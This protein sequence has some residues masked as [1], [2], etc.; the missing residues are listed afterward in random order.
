MLSRKKKEK[1]NGITLGCMLD[2]VFLLLSIFC[3]A[4]GKTTVW[5]EARQSY[6]VFLSGHWWK[7]KSCQ[8][9]VVIWIRTPSSS[10]AMPVAE[11]ICPSPLE[12][13]H[14]ALPPPSPHITIASHLLWILSC[15][16]TTAHSHSI[17]FPFLQGPHKVNH[18][19]FARDGLIIALACLSP[20]C[21]LHRDNRALLLIRMQLVILVFH[22]S[23]LWVTVIPGRSE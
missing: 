12:R 22:T 20:S 8:S 18:N 14:E 11:V 2:F 7:W 6:F 21:A 3:F 10:T 4:F 13:F 9:A 5:H 19:L 16:I 23:W 1:R 17:P 15:S